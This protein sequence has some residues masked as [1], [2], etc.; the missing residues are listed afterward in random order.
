MIGPV[1]GTGRAMMASLQQ[2]MSKGMPPDQAIQYVKSMATQGVAPL[3]DLYAM[4]NQFQ[5]LK[6]QQVQPPQTPPT[7]KDQLNMAEQQQQMQAQQGGIA[8]MQAPPPAP[9]PMD[10]GLGAIDAGRMEYPKFAGGGV[11]ALANGDLLGNAEE[12]DIIK[13][14][15]PEFETMSPDQQNAVRRYLDPQIKQAKTRRAEGPT[16]REETGKRSN[17]Q[18][19]PISKQYE[20]ALERANRPIAGYSAQL[21][22]EAEARGEGKAAQAMR[23]RLQK[24]GEEIEPESKRTRGLALAQIGAQIMEAA[25]RP[26]ATGLGSIGAGF[27]RGIPAMMELQQRERELRQRY[28]DRMLDLQQAEELRQ[29]GYDKEA[30]ALASQARGEA[31]ALAKTL[32]DNELAMERL[33]FSEGEATKRTRLQ[34]LGDT[35]RATAQAAA[36]EQRLDALVTTETRKKLN[37]P[38]TAPRDYTDAMREYNRA[39]T[40]EEFQAAQEKVRNI[41]EREKALV[42]GEYGVT[43]GAGTEID[44]SNMFPPR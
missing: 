17:D 26:G 6:Q 24:R 44:F 16:V 15:V 30:R 38:L 25:S 3:T 20:T 21:R 8:G 7:I 19:I 10:R 41:F 13:Q 28:E 14:F 22:A 33:R 2:A 9:Q 36:Y 34:E 32:G 35:R 18:I 29:A 23:E 1:S 4:M 43:G 27:A 39:K 40:P 42:R 12:L 37:N 5:R 31:N 11:V